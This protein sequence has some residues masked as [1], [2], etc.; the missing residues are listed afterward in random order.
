MPKRPKQHQLE[1]L[2]RAKFQLC[3]PEEWVIRDKDKDYGIDCEVELFDEDEK[4]H[5]NFI[6][7]AIKGYRFKERI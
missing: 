2:S 3:L 1:D 6:L 7:C 4:F 5:R